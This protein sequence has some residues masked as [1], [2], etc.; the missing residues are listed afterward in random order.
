MASFITLVRRVFQLGL[1]QTAEFG[2][3]RGRRAP[4]RRDRRRGIHVHAGARARPRSHVRR[5][6]RVSTAQTRH[7]SASSIARIAWSVQLDGR[8]A[9]CGGDRRRRVA[10]ATSAAAPRAA[11]HRET[12]RPATRIA[13]SAAAP[14]ARTRARGS[15]PRAA[16]RGARPTASRTLRLRSAPRRAATAPA[17]DGGRAAQ[18]RAE[19]SASLAAR[20]AG[21]EVRGPRRRQRAS[22][23]STNLAIG[24]RCVIAATS[25]GSSARERSSP[26]PRRPSCRGSR[27]S[28]RAAARDT[29]AG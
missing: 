5:R 22:T 17:L 6:R 29:R 7:P 26:S 19:P 9:R 20:G 25:S 13:T 3:L 18:R 28:P 15:S 11:I 4:A 23:R 21:L 16:R 14:A 12:A 10:T 1:Q 8:K 24:E 2:Q 27:R